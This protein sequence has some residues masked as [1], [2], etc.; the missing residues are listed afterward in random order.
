MRLPL[1]IVQQRTSISDNIISSIAGGNGGTNTGGIISNHGEGGNSCGIYI[2]SSEGRIARIDHIS[3]VILWDY[4]VW[5]LFFWC[6]PRKKSQASNQ[7]VIRGMIRVGSTFAA[8]Q[9]NCL[10]RKA[11]LSE[12][13][14]M[15][16]G[17]R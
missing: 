5:R 3:C 13:R 14:K 2:D 6:L 15:P 12:K 11:V 7:P 10:I 8:K 16:G 4:L 17:R 9:P 1:Q